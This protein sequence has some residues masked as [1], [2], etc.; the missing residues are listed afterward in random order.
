MR[1]SSYNP[2]KG[3][4][5]API[6]VAKQYE[7]SSDDSTEDTV[8]YTPLLSGRIRGNVFEPEGTIYI[9]AEVS[10]AGRTQILGAAERGVILNIRNVGGAVPGII[11]LTNADAAAAAGNTVATTTSIAASAEFGFLDTD[12]K[13]NEPLLHGPVWAI[14]SASTFRIVIQ[15]WEQ[16]QMTTG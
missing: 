1:S 10:S 15:L 3:E 4:L 13:M 2:A 8:L 12:G 6:P 9:S 5:L 7:I 16:T 11:T 14:A